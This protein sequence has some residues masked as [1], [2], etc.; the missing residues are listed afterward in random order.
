LGREDT[1][2]KVGIQGHANHGIEGDANGL[3]AVSG[4]LFEFFRES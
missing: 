4:A 2:S 1:G 3:G